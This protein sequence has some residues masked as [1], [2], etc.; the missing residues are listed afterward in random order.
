MSNG[1][2]RIRR[3][4][5]RLLVA[6]IVALVLAAVVFG[7]WIAR[8]G[9]VLSVVTAPRA[10]RT[11][12]IRRV[13]PGWGEGR[14]IFGVMIFDMTVPLDPG[15]R[16]LT[17]GGGGSYLFGFIVC[18]PWLNQ[19]FVARVTLYEVDSAKLVWLFGVPAVVFFVWSWRVKPPPPNICTICGYDLRAHQPGQRCPECGTE[20]PSVGGRSLK[21]GA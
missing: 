5:R 6:G 4:K 13:D 2:M 14:S 11:V 1:A 3:R 17:P 9:L 8:E 20:I 7:F 15:P 21:G 18:V 12:K 19:A 16:T 10:A